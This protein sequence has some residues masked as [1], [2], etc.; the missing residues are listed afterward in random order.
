VAEL[1]FPKT[2][3]LGSLGLDEVFLYHDG[4]HLFSCRNAETGTLYIATWTGEVSGGDSW[5]VAPVSRRQLQRLKSGKI[6]I[7]ELFASPP[8][9]A[10]YK[11]FVSTSSDLANV[12]QT[13]ASHLGEEFLPEPGERLSLSLPSRCVIH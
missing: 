2:A 1:C 7:R 11:I 4:P 13:P 8:G 3:Q 5:I 12:E 9:D 10:V 6:D